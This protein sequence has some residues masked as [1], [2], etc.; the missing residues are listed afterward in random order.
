MKDQKIK[1]YVTCF[2]NK[3]L[4]PDNEL[5]ELVQG[6]AA[7]APIRF[8]GMSHDD[9]GDNISRLNARFNDMATIYWVWKNCDNDY[10]GFM[11]YRRF[12]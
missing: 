5:F 2:N 8:S 11:Q 1:I 4:V 3:I 12:I 7:N 10:Y 9:E 6:G